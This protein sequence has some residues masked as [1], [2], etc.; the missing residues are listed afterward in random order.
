MYKSQ[1]GSVL[2]FNIVA[3]SGNLGVKRRAKLAR[4]VGMV[5]ELGC[6]EEGKT[7][8]YRRHGPGTWV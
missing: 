2:T 3:W 5:Q 4:I 6:E 7:G 8:T 1:V